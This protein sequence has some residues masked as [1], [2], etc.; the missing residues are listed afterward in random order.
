MKFYA[1]INSAGKIVP[2]YD[3]DYDS[4]RKVKRNTELLIEVKQQRNP[5]HHRKFFALIN[6][7][8]DN[9]EIFTDI[10]Q[11]RKELTIEAGFYNEYTT[12]T[13]EIKREAKSISF[14]SMDQIE[15]NE[16]Y[17]KFC[18]AVIRVMN[19]SSQDIEENL[20]SYL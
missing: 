2:M 3:S 6:M 20:E 5:M 17:S 19:W 16:L 7:V 14:S 11:L 4:F 1:E 12:F 9:Q 13:G 18:D 8:F 10:E 15:F